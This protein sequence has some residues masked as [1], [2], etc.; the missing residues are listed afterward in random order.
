M[1]EIYIANYC[2]PN[3]SPLNSITRLSK[4]EA[5]EKAKDLSNKYS[6][7]AFGRFADFENYY[8][9]RIQTEEWLYNW[10]IKL[11]GEPET[12]HPLYFVLHGSDFLDN[13]FDKGKVTKLPLNNISSKHISFTFGDSMAK[14]EKIERKNPF[15]KETLLEL[16][17]RFNGDVN[18]LLSSIKEQYTYIEVQLWSDKYYREEA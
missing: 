5:F 8:P 3:C 9:R 16:T 4:S 1:Q 13:W 15:L 10:F 11:G 2:N 14:F 17:N 18:Q 7:T 12:E 6:G